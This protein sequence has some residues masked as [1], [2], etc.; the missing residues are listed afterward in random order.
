MVDGV[1]ELAPV[2]PAHKQLQEIPQLLR[3]GFEEEGRL[4]GI[5]AV[6]VV[7]QGCRV[8]TVVQ[9]GARVQLDLVGFDGFVESCEVGRIGPSLVAGVG[10]FVEAAAQPRFDQRVVLAHRRL[11]PLLEF[12][13]DH[14]R[15]AFFVVAAQNKV[16]ALG[17]HRQLALDAHASI[18][19][20]AGRHERHARDKLLPQL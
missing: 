3:V 11:A 5:A 7:E 15:V 6:A 9:E 10:R 2:A 8:R 13:D 16:D 14:L 1:H 17:A 12:D 18:L 4:R 19:R 20:Q